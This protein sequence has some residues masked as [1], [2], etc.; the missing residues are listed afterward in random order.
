M[1]PCNPVWH[2]VTQCG[3]IA[4]NGHVIIGLY[5][6]TIEKNGNVIIEMDLCLYLFSHSKHLVSYKI[7]TIAFRKNFKY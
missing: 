4:Q 6:D 3:S 2:N 5:H 1:V 7:V